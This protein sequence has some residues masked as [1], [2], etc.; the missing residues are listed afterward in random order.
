MWITDPWFWAFLATFG[1]FLA[2]FVVGYKA[3]GSNPWFGVFCV[4]LVEVPRIILPMGFV[5]QPRFETGGVLIGLGVAILI[6]SL[7]FASPV[8]RIRPFTR[9]QRKEALRTDGL[10]AI[11]RHPLYVCD[12]FWPLGWSLICGSIIGVA[13]TPVWFAAVY[14]LT[15]FEEHKL[16]E[17]YGDEYAQYRLRTPRLIPFLKSH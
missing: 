4:T 14:L 16:L 8:F 10:Y 11:V 6:I 7:V 5:A 17:E 1:W 9:P 12:S 2:P 13:L 15:L 3:T